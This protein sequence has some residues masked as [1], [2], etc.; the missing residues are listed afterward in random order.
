VTD[1]QA[2]D[3]TAHPIVRLE[4]D[5]NNLLAHGLEKPSE[6]IL[7][8][9]GAYYE[10]IGGAGT[11]GA[12]TIVYGG[13]DNAGSADGTDC[14]A[15]LNAA[16]AA[17]SQGDKIFVKSGIYTLTASV[18]ENVGLTIEGEHGAG[19]L[20]FS[21]DG[22]HGGYSTKNGV[23]FVD[24]DGTG[25]DM[26][27]LGYATS[28]GANTMTWGHVLKN[29]AFSGYSTYPAVYTDYK[30][31]DA[32][33][34]SNIQT[35]RF[36][37]LAFYHKDVG[38]YVT[39][40]NDEAPLNW[41]DA[42]Y[43]H[44]IYG[45]FNRRVIYVS[46]AGGEWRFDNIYGYINQFNCLRVDAYYDVWINN[47][48]SIVDGLQGADF[49]DGSAIRLQT[50]YGDFHVS[51]VFINGAH[52]AGV[53]FC[54]AGIAVSLSATHNKSTAF[55]NNV[56]IQGLD[57]NAIEID[58]G[59]A[60]CNVFIRDV[61]IGSPNTDAMMTETNNSGDV[62]GD[63]VRV[64]ETFG[65][66]NVYVDGGY[67]DC[68]QA[69]KWGAWFVGVKS[70]R[71]LSNYNPL[72]KPGGGVD[73]IDDVNDT[74]GVSGSN[75]AT[76]PS[77]STDYTVYGFPII[78]TSTDSGNADCSIDIDDPNG[79]AMLSGASTLTREY[80]PVGYTINWGAFT[81]AAPTVEIWGV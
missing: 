32:V 39:A 49:N 52:S 50:D 27:K 81:G 1:F 10:A 68:E 42:I 31:N 37:N 36:E 7:R 22:T 48:H 23:L 17:C 54:Y 57:S 5:W 46:S 53:E 24:G 21:D 29:L 8:V 60:G 25:I 38:L 45:A 13:P 74:I 64:S 75:D 59:A 80:V 43:F 9:N 77:A 15:V 79:V 44:N 67:V 16:I 56:L 58:Q 66:I 14:A 12:G 61:Y 51:N 33:T 3:Y 40:T 34:C 4:D 11:S 19:D 6:Y 41:S 72:G 20:F 78:V 35:S 65:N 28:G 69:S 73:F 18:N 30:A 71:N 55:I 76:A 26:F 63:V 2:W 62:S 47:V 70:I